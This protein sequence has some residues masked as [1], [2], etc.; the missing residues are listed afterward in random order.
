[1]TLEPLSARSVA[2][3]LLLGAPAASLTARELTTLGST[4]EIAPATMRVA[5]SRLVAAGDLTVAD[6][7]YALHAR[8][9]DRRRATDAALRPPLRAHDGRW[10]L[11]VVTERGRALPARVALRTELAAARFAELREGVWLRPDNLDPLAAPP[12]VTALTA[13]PDDEAALAA[14]LW[15]L[16][17]WAARARELLTLLD[18][19]GA[20]PLRRLT[21]A[22]AVVRLLRLDPLL[23]SEL[24]PDGWPG[25]SVR[26]RYDAYRGE[27]AATL[28]AVLHPPPAPPSPTQEPT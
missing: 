19:P 13:T 26:A 3:S 14:R 4:F 11:L 21:V 16:P 10:R 2:L 6:T 9:R 27:L 7:A 25:E 22:A 8:H 28:A 23:P 12:D 17:G 15:D 24:L 20:S 5:L 18:E 1:M